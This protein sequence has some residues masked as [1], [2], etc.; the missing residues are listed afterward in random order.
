MNRSQIL[1]NRKTWIK[2][3]KDPKSKKSKHRLGD[4][5]TGGMCCLGHGCE[6]LKIERRDTLYQVF[7][8]NNPSYPPDSFV[9]KVGLYNRHGH[10][11]LVGIYKRYG[12]I[13]LDKESIKV[14]GNK[15]TVGNTV[16]LSD[17]NDDTD[18]TPQEIGLYLESVI[19]GGDDSP[20]K[21]LSE[22]P[23]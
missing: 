15:Y 19:D 4:C 17:L 12:H 13:R 7:Y 1:E 10:I 6:A 11:R 5:Y 3:L 22:Y 14:N 23:E 18:I 20:F 2:R 21:P 8:E 9:E 16:S